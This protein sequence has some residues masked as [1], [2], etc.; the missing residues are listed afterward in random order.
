MSADEVTD[1]SKFFNILI[2][3]TSIYVIVMLII[4]Y[5]SLIAPI[6]TMPDKFSDEYIKQQQQLSIE[7]YFKE[8]NK[9]P[10][11]GNRFYNYAKNYS[12]KF[13]NYFKTTINWFYDNRNFFIVLFTGFGFSTLTLSWI[14]YYE[15]TTI[16]ELKA[17]GSNITQ[18][19]LTDKLKNLKIDNAKKKKDGD[20]GEEGRKAKKEKIMQDIENKYNGKN[21]QEDFNKR[22]FL[23]RK[24]N[25]DIN[26]YNDSANN[27]NRSEAKNISEIINISLYDT[28]KIPFLWVTGLTIL[29]ILLLLITFTRFKLEYIQIIVNVLI[30]I[31]LA[32]LLYDYFEEFQTEIG[33]ALIFFII[34]TMLGG[35]IIGSIF[36]V[37]GYFAGYYLNLYLNQNKPEFPYY[38]NILNFINLA[39]GFLPCL[40]INFA[41]WIKEEYLKTSKN[42]LILLGIEALLIAFKFLIPYIYSLFKKVFSP[43]ENIL[44]VNPVPL[45][46]VHNLGLF[47]TNE[48]VKLYNTSK[49]DTSDKFFNYNYAIA[50][51]LWIFPQPKS[52]SDA[53][54]KSSN[55]INI[56]D[57]V[58][59][60]HNNN[61]IEFWAA[62]TVPGEN[63]NRLIKLYEYK[64]FKYQKWNNIII[65]YQGGSIDIFINKSLKSSTPNITPLKNNNSAVIGDINGINGGIKNVSYF[66]KAL[67]Q[68]DINL[69]V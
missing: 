66:K 63:P 2:I 22:I 58:K 36:A 1:P 26:D 56:S 57:I 27:F 17:K 19:E 16:K 37:I 59:V 24:I 41:I 39:A 45:D 32:S 62:T 54:T 4:I 20:E 43:K 30:L 6:K 48:D 5:Y 46:R 64:E 44:L 61:T 10:K 18:K 60:I 47:L 69:K 50:F 42:I 28:I 40:F 52:V 51:S 12:M 35:L 38:K 3:A 65:N 25:K 14:N 23:E 8:K 13:T 15:S 21:T 67:S 31:G 34:F 29:I 53:Y 33:I 68:Q 7:N 9:E 55:L 11:S 49:L